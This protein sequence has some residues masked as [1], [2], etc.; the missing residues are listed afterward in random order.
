MKV[1]GLQEIN[2]YFILSL[3]EKEGEIFKVLPRVAINLGGNVTCF[4]SSNFLK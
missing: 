4:V 2:T 3:L 1:S